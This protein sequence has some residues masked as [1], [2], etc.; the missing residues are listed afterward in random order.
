MQFLNRTLLI[1]RLKERF[2]RVVRR[3]EINVD[4]EEDANRVTALTWGT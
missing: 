4:K 1:G 2:K 3:F